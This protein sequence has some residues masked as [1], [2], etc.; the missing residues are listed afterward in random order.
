MIHRMG[1]FQLFKHKNKEQSIEELDVPP[2]PPNLE[3][4]PEISSDKNFNNIEDFAPPELPNLEGGQQSDFQTPQL[5]EP[6]PDSSKSMEELAPPELLPL[7]NDFPKK[8]EPLSFPDVA[9]QK[10]Y[11]TEERIGTRLDEMIPEA[12]VQEETFTE[13]IAYPAGPMFINMRNFKEVIQNINSMRVD[14]KKSED[15]IGIILDLKA[16]KEVEFERWGKTLEDIQKKLM[17][18]DKTLFN[19]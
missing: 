11:N 6:L 9:F 1:M 14:L 18:A 7:E 12:N 2:E 5:P 10:N 16:N 19:G 15:G 13:T 17:Y 3:D 8:K 4:H